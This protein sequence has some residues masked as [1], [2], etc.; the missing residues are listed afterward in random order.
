MKYGAP[1]TVKNDFASA[2]DLYSATYPHVSFEYRVMDPETYES[3]LLAAWSR[4]EGPD[5]FSVPNWRL[6]SF[7]QFISPMPTGELE[8]R[9]TE[10]RR[11]LGRQVTDVTTNTVIFPT[12]NQLR[13]QFVEVVADDITSNNQVYGLPLS[14]DTLALYYNRDLLAQAG[15]ATPPATWDEFVTAVQ[16]MTTLNTARQVVQPAAGIGTADNVP[17]AFDLVSAIMM[18]NGAVM[19]DDNQNIRFAQEVDGRAVPP[20]IEGVDFYTKFA[21]PQFATYTWDTTQADAREVFTQ[22]ELP[23]YFGYWEDQATLASRAPELPLSVT[24]LPQID[25]TI[26]V[27]YARYTIETV[28]IG[29]DVATHAWNFL[30]YIATNTEAAQAFADTTGRPGRTQSSSWCTATNRRPGS[31]CQASLNRSRLVPWSESRRRHT[32]FCRYGQ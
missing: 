29:S 19:A 7:R 28:H 24:A 23:M 20:G 1:P 10:T 26:T 5:I 32:D 16:T 25:P 4:G 30:R 27:N 13:D 9:R 8:L 2:I 31:I 22:G 15:I 17:Y 6:G 11:S 21:K 3:E 18:Q 14:V 12:A